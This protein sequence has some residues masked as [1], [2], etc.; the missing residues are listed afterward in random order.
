MI[1]RVARRQCADD[2]HMWQGATCCWCGANRKRAEARGGNAVK[3][4]TDYTSAYDVR[5]HKGR[6]ATETWP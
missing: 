4:A 1:D 3:H 6:T 2:G 5:K